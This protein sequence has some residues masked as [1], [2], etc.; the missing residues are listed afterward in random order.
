MQTE[1]D[2]VGTTVAKAARVASAAEGGQI[3][4]SLTTAGLVNTSE[5]EFGPQ[6]TVELKGLDEAQQL[7]SLIW[8]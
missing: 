1:D 2:Y 8:S 7:Q 5:F 4:V 3:L 6:I